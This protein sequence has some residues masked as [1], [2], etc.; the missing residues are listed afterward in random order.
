MGWNHQP[1]E[2]GFL[3]LKMLTCSKIDVELKVCD[4]ISG[5]MDFF[6]S[7]CRSIGNKYFL[8]F[9]IFVESLI[10]TYPCSKYLERN[11]IPKTNM[12]TQNDGF[13]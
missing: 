4:A 9:P 2:V 1:V 13:F 3:G 11:D 12:D 10:V 6:E 8:S 7:P 5:E